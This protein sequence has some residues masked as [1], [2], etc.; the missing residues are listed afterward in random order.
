MNPRDART[1][2]AVIAFTLLQENEDQTKILDL[3]RKI[4]DELAH[5]LL[6]KAGSFEPFD[7][8]TPGYEELAQDLLGR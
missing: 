2:G 7:E 8:R 1:P 4:T 6:M 3:T 5:W